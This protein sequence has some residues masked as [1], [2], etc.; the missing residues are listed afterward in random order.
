MNTSSLFPLIFL[1]LLGACGPEKPKAPEQPAQ[2][3]VPLPVEE[4]TTDTI[5][6]PTTELDTTQWI[7]LQWLDPS[8]MKDI[9]YAT[10]NNFVKEQLYECPRCLLRPEV[11]YRMVSAQRELQQKGLG[12][13]VFDCYRPRPVQEKLW[14][15]VPDA[16]YVT[17]PSKGS[18]HN[19]GSAVDLTIVDQDGKELDMGTDYDYFGREAYH[20][21][22]DLD[23]TVLANRRLLKETMAT[24]ELSP[25]RTEWWHYSY[26]GK[27]YPLADM[28]W[29]CK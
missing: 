12:L 3:E 6:Q 26:R 19:R 20:D 23:S 10:S 17:P 15:K 8:I 28:L 14:E 18:M 24:I 9:R 16:R 4:P 5:Q 1:L 2:T 22:T 21:Y 29:E 7:D 13:K 27:S 11:A 25:I